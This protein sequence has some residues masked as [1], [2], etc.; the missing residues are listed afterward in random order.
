MGN[1]RH[2]RGYWKPFTEALEAMKP[3]DLL[4][5]DV[6]DADRSTALVRVQE[7]NSTDTR[8]ASNWWGGKLFI[9][10]MM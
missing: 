7:R 4:I 1:Q 10:R 2:E 9:V 5:W 3:H 6:A 8:Y